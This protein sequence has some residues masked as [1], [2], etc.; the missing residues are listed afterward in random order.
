MRSS[1][2][3]LRAQ[4]DEFGGGLG[5]QYLSKRHQQAGVH[6][7]FAPARG[8]TMANCFSDSTL[9]SN[10]LA[11]QLADYFPVDTQLRT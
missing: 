2:V 3:G 7:Y 6:F 11:L 8:G 5:M 9:N 1:S 10:A 4:R